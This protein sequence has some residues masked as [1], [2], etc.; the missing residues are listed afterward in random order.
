[1]DTTA[2]DLNNAA[3]EIG[4]NIEQQLSQDSRED[5]SSGNNLVGEKHENDPHSSGSSSDDIAQ[6]KDVDS[7]IVKV[8]DVK[9]GEEAY[10]HLPPHEREVVKRQL[11]IPEVK[12]TFKTLYRYATRN[13]LII[14]AVSSICAIAGGSVMPLMTVSALSL[15]SGNI[16]H[17]HAFP[18]HLWSTGRHIP[19]PLPRYNFAFR[20]Q[21]SIITLYPLLYLPCGRRVHY[22]LCLYRWIHLHWRAYRR[23]D[24]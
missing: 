17:T 11:D 9:E 23:E 22:H 5:S 24:P 6:L 20:F 7:H 16:Q 8:P 21:R 10:A 4:A 15:S 3:K 12:V 14:I 19:G 13:D 18:G 1:M 2:G